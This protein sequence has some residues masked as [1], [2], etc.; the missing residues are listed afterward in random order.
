M[1]FSVKLFAI[2]CVVLAS[3][4]NGSPVEVAEREP[5]AQPV[6]SVLTLSTSPSPGRQ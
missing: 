3:A 4:V 5:P 2:I 6:R 1:V